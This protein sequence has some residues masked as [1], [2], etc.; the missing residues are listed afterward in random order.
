MS[1]EL[2]DNKVEREA[3]L[4]EQLD[5]VYERRTAS[6]EQTEKDHREMSLDAYVEKLS[7]HLPSELKERI[8]TKIDRLRKTGLSE[9]DL[10]NET[11]FESKE[12]L[13]A[14]TDDFGML[15]KGYEKLV[16][17]DKIDDIFKDKP[18]V[19]DLKKIARISW[20]LNGLRAVNNLNGGKHANGDRYIGIAVEVLND[21]SIRA[22]AKKFGMEISAIH[23][24][25][26]EF[27]ATVISGGPIEPGSK[28]A[29]YLNQLKEI[30]HDKIF[31]HSS[32]QEILNVEDPIVKA[33]LT[34]PMNKAIADCR[35]NNVK[36]VFRA[37]MSGDIATLYEALMGEISEKNR[38]ADS[39]D[40]QKT[41]GKLMGVLIDASDSRMK[42]K[43]KADKLGLAGSDNLNDRF[44]ASI[45]N[46]GE[47]SAEAN[48]ELSELKSEK[49]RLVGGYADIQ[50]I[51]D[52]GGSI[53]DIKEILK[54]F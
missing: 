19:D 48:R 20:D 38:L 9:E 32:A 13:E 11:E 42:E 30:I 47:E 41:L 46:M 49:A 24:S 21:P 22:L 39:D 23:E 33:N 1:Q 7:A 27:A 4:Q 44:L 54:K 6:A 10:K 16:V 51:I 40:Y 8:Q 25:G 45:Y 12:V 17:K 2:T 43:K 37:W 3:R 52:A 36:P 14:F 34:A 28:E 18:K 50:K 31:R 29:E 53:N 15:N 35:E 26:D 5:K